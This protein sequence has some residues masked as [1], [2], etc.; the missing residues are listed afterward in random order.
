MKLY[1]ELNKSQLL[2]NILIITLLNIKL[3]MFHKYHILLLL[4]KSQYKDLML[5]KFQYKELLL[6]MFQKP[7]TPLN[8]SHN[9]DKLK[10]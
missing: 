4:I 10:M 9:K 8:M 6:N 1:K 5:N 7:D 3:N 2:D